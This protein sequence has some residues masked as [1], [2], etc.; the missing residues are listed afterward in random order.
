MPSKLRN[1]ELWFLIF[2]KYYYS[3]KIKENQ[4]G[5]AC[6]AYG[7]QGKWVEGVGRETWREDNNWKTWT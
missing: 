3:D 4:V 1:Y 2:A 6:D 5:G 7:R